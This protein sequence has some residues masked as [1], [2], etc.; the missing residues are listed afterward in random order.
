MSNHPL[1]NTKRG[2]G[3][4]A[5][6]EN[7][8]RLIST[9]HTFTQVAEAI[10]ENSNAVVEY[11]I[12]FDARQKTTSITLPSELAMDLVIIQSKW[13]GNLLKSVDP[14]SRSEVLGIPTD[15]HYRR[16]ASISRREPVEYKIALYPTP[17]K[18]GTLTLYVIK[19]WI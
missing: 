10:Q 6:I 16:C 1:R 13:N 9:H 14:L 8:K 15:V 5:R 19:S 2:R 4:Q 12:P 11:N 17:K 7:A 3:L 18:S